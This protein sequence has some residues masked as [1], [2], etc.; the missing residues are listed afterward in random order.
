MIGLPP[1]EVDSRRGVDGMALRNESIEVLEPEEGCLNHFSDGS[2][3]EKAASGILEIP[4]EAGPRAKYDTGID[5]V[6]T[7]EKISMTA[8]RESGEVVRPRVDG[9]HERRLSVDDPVFL[10]NP[11]YFAH[12]DGGLQHMFEHGLDHDCVDRSTPERDLVS[13]CDEL[14]G[15]GS[16]DIEG[17]DVKTRIA[18]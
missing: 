4:E 18:V 14:N 6:K 9:L 15:G 17:D 10:E 13:I 16:V 5:A 2:R 1:E 3:S 7:L 12:D 11:V 8:F